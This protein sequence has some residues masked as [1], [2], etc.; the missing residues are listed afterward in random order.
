MK[1]R[2]SSCESPIFRNL[3]EPVPWLHSFLNALVSVGARRLDANHITSVPEDSFE[4]L[5]QLR[6]LWLDDNSLTEVP[7]RPLSH[8][9]T[10]QALTLALNK[11]SSIPDFAFTNLSSLV[12]L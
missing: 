6:H 2:G 10:L 11:I 1:E 8:L 4:G 3:C 7:V 12:V 9:P 5:V